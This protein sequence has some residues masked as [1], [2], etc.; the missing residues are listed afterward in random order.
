MCAIAR[1]VLQQ[2]AYDRPLRLA[3]LH[4]ALR[5]R[6]LRPWT[7]GSSSSIAFARGG[8]W[9][10]RHGR[11]LAR[12]HW[13]GI[14]SHPGA[15]R[16]WETEPGSSTNLTSPSRACDAL[17]RPLTRAGALA[18]LHDALAARARVPERSRPRLNAFTGV[19]AAKPMVAPTPAVTRSGRIC[20][21]PRQTSRIGLGAWRDT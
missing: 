9:L 20:L 11:R 4:A 17:T 2:R 12:P 14:G 19:K 15:P 8:G 13:Q 3:L 1:E 21:E 5:Q 7:R 10:R 18:A 16:I 6:Y